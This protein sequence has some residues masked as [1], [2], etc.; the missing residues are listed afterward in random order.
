[1]AH[2]LL[3]STL[4]LSHFFASPLPLLAS[5]EDG[6]LSPDKSAAYWRQRLQRTDLSQEECLEA[7]QL[8]GQDPSQT[9]PAADAYYQYFS[10]APIQLE[11]LDLT[12]ESRALYGNALKVFF[13]LN[14]HE[15]FMYRETYSNLMRW[16]L[17]DSQTTPDTLLTL[18]DEFR[19]FGFE[20]DV[21]AASQLYVWHPDK[22]ATDKAHLF[23]AARAH[24]IAQMADQASILYSLAIRQPSQ[25]VTPSKMREA[26]LHFMSTHNAEKGLETYKKMFST[27]S[28][29]RLTP[30]DFLN[31]AGCAARVRDNKS[32]SDLLAAYF[33]H[34]MG[35]PLPLAYRLRATA[36]SRAGDVETAKEYWLLAMKSGVKM[37]FADYANAA[38][39]FKSLGDVE[40]A[41]TYWKKAL[42]AQ[43]AAPD[44]LSYHAACTVFLKVCD[45]ENAR[46]AA[47]GMLA[48]RA[49][50]PLPEGTVDDLI[51]AAMVYSHNSDFEKSIALWEKIISLKPKDETAYLWAGVDLYRAGEH[52]RASDTFCKLSDKKIKE[53]C[54]KKDLMEIMGYCHLMAGRQA[55]ARNILLHAHESSAPSKAGRKAKASRGTTKKV[56][57]G[58]RRPKDLSTLKVA[59]CAA[60]VE[61]MQDMLSHLNRGAHGTLVDI[62]KQMVMHKEQAEALLA[63]MH[64]E[65]SHTLPASP[66]SGEESLTDQ[67]QPPLPFTE[68]QR[69]AREVESLSH[70]YKKEKSSIDHLAFKE[71]RQRVIAQATEEESV[72]FYPAQAS[73][74]TKAPAPKREKRKTRGKASPT[75]KCASNASS[76]SAHAV[77]TSKVEWRLTPTAQKHLSDL[78]SVPGFQGKFETF[79]QEIEMEPWGR[80]GN[81]LTHASG[82]A[83]LLNGYDNVFSRRFSKGDRF[84]YRVERQEDGRVV[85]TILGLMGHDLS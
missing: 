30:T 63:Q 52:T 12:P 73:S 31:A 29:D 46:V 4:L 3:I 51:L 23:K 71:Y 72:A 40:L 38:Q 8:L 57:K 36:A 80:R 6:S 83:K 81:A 64:A 75:K 2:K 15:K 67:S 22:S 35:P 84:F 69:L 10:H 85:V 33:D 41:A 43:D 26:A 77:N 76:A 65:A 59:I 39:T 66:L 27:F 32:T 20:D 11:G 70:L 21:R 5:S 62:E 25:N 60:S 45:Y 42:N 18:M 61:K 34:E 47:D 37:F 13:S 44:Y 1:M 50:V 74:N 9:Y 79:R 24:E 78:R 54:Q 49:T 19:A 48:S 7:A 53:H 82:R 17:R 28:H 55:E 56:Q 14:Q 68:I 16:H 58:G